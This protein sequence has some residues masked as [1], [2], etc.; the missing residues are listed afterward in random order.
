V[1]SEIVDIIDEND[2]VL[3]QSERKAAFENNLL[4][5]VVHAFLIDRATKKLVLL[6]RSKNASFRPLHYGLIGGY[7]QT[8]ESWEQGVAREVA[9]EAGVA[10]NL[11]FL[12]KGL[13]KDESNGKQFMDGVFAGWINAD[14]L[15]IDLNDLERVEL[16]TIEELKT[17]VAIEPKIHPLLP[18][19]VKVFLPH[20]GIMIS[21]K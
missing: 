9:E 4:C 8:G 20:Y 19:Q 7:V 10:P 5:R 3:Y 15:V 21:A 2:Q 6:V 11:V 12:G 17:L 18:R 16:V 13:A 1:S 14:D